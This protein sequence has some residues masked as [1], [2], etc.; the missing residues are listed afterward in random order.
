MDGERVH[1]GATYNADEIKS[2]WE[3]DEKPPSYH[4]NLMTTPEDKNLHESLE[5]FWLQEHCG[6]VAEDD[7]AMSKEDVDACLVLEEGTKK[8]GDH[9]EVPM[10]WSNSKEKLQN[11][12]PVAKK[13]FGFLQRRL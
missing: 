2:F 7:L 11:N 5:R 1:C 13:R 9:Y 12:L 10:L 6:I 4:V 3:P 8:V